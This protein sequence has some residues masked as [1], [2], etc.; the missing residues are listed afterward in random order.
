[1]KAFGI[2]RSIELLG[3][4][5]AAYTG[6]VLMA[7]GYLGF[8]FATSGWMMYAFLVPFALGGIAMPAVRGLLSN[9]V[10]ADQQ[11][12]LAGA[13]TSLFSFTAVIAPLVMTQLFAYWS[14]PEAPFYFPGAA[15]LVAGLLTLLAAALF[16]AAYPR[17]TSPRADPLS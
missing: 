15:F 3:P 14:S 8:A 7:A 6:F 4:R 11:G 16:G 10:P 2:R 1:M 9:E 12:E 17:A 13:I 5:G